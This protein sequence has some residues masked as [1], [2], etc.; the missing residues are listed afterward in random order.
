[1]FLVITS[2]DPKDKVVDIFP[3]TCLQLITIDKKNITLIVQERVNCM[4]YDLSTH[5]FKN[6][7]NINGYLPDEVIKY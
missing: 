5:N 6:V 3:I 1:M 2:Q 7:D 4:E